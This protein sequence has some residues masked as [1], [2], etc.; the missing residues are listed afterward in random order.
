MCLS[1]IT[2]SK[3][4]RTGDHLCGKTHVW[5]MPQGEFHHHRFLYVMEQL[6]IRGQDE[7]ARKLAGLV[8]ASFTDGGLPCPWDTTIKA[9]L[10]MLDTVKEV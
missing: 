1:I 4:S 7:T 9:H 3:D 5:P 2:V 10:T 6:V 8:Q